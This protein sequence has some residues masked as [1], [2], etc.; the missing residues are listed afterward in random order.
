MDNIRFLSDRYLTLIVVLTILAIILKIFT[1]I[2]YLPLTVDGGWTAYP[3]L[4]MS[5]GGMAT[6]NAEDIDTLKK[7]KGVAV[8]Y[9][10]D[11]RSVRLFLLSG[12]YKSFKSSLFSCRIY[13][14]LEYLLLIVVAYFF[15]LRFNRD[16]RIILLIL[17]IYATDKAL[18]SA[19]AD[20]RPDIF[21]TMLT[22]LG[23]ILFD[24]SV[25]SKKTFISWLAL[26]TLSILALTWPYTAMP[27]SLIFVY[28]I[29]VFLVENN[30]SIAKRLPL[31]LIL[32]ALPTVLFFLR[33]N[34]ND[35]LFG[36]LKIVDITWNPELKELWAGG[37]TKLFYKEIIRWSGYFLD[38][39][40]IGLLVILS[41]LG[42]VSFRVIT[43][44][45]RI[46]NQLI[47]LG[48]SVLVGILVLL[49]ADKQYTENHAFAVVPFLFGIVAIICN[50]FTS[51]KWK[52]ISYLFLLAY[53]SLSI[54]LT[55]IF[56]LRTAIVLNNSG[57]NNNKVS[58]FVN[59]I[60]PDKGESILAIG[61]TAL[62]PNMSTQGNFTMLDDRTGNMLELVNPCEFSYILIDSEYVL[63]GYEE[64]FRK[65]FR[66]FDLKKLKVFGDPLNLTGYLK[67]LGIEKTFACG[68]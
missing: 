1:S 47:P 4:S 60:M 11:T 25:S 44:N 49:V 27:L 56:S 37:V 7:I 65:K 62:F 52:P 9:N 50:S 2:R 23:F 21:I 36:D 22:M 34:I 18:L 59:G 48:I 28:F 55:V 41:A 8:K 32:I 24:I 10:F 6:E 42:A 57:Y 19:I 26:L 15:L 66:S 12:W 54:I 35:M 43:L 67:V 51:K 46:P 30:L 68:S 40:I 38:S 63:Y 58:A 13:S 29:V 14:L 17:C 61:P 53:V 45:Q 3:A 39:N 64:K 20:L 16:K 33:S 31:L 5:R